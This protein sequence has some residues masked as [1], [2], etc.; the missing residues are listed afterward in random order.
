MW[1]QLKALISSLEDGEAKANLLVGFDKLQDFSKNDMADAISNRD[2]AKAD[3]LPSKELIKAL[4]DATGLGE[5]LSADTVK[6]L[7]DS[8]SKGGAEVD[9]LTSQLNELRKINSDLETTHNEFVTTSNEKSFEL[10]ISQSDIF[11]DVSSD[12]FLRSAVLSAIKPKLTVGEDG[13][14]YAKNNDNSIMNDLVSGK[15]ITGQT[16]FGQMVESGAISK[17]ALNGTVGSGTGGQ[18]N[19]G[20]NNLPSNSTLSATEMM[21]QAR[22]A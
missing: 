4:Q 10:A 22:K 19:G 12:P 21:K 18:Q 9:A 17:S 5:S 14:I 3:L 13:Q 8:K 6:T 11:K 1:E 2:K 15:P 16:L 20:G 7:I